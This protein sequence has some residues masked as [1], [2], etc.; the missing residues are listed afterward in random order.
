[1][2]I[3]HHSVTPN[4]SSD[5]SKFNQSPDDR[6]M[7][8]KHKTE[9]LIEMTVPLNDLIPIIKSQRNAKSMF[10]ENHD[11]RKRVKGKSKEKN[12][13]SLKDHNKYLF[14]TK[15]NELVSSD[16]NSEKKS[17]NE[18]RSKDS[19]D[20]YNFQES[21]I[22]SRGK[23]RS[24]RISVKH[25][26][27]SK[28]SP[29]LGNTTLNMHTSTSNK[30]QTGR[31]EK[32]YIQ[33]SCDKIVDQKMKDKDDTESGI[34]IPEPDY[35]P[36]L[37]R[38][39]TGQEE[40]V[41]FDYDLSLFQHPE[42]KKNSPQNITNDKN[43]KARSPT[44]WKN[45][46][47]YRGSLEK[48]QIE[49]YHDAN[50]VRDEK[51]Q[52]EDGTGSGYSK[53][54][55]TKVANTHKS[56]PHDT[57]EPYMADK[58][59]SKHQIP[60]NYNPNPLRT[61]EEAIMSLEKALTGRS[62]VKDMVEKLKKETER[63]KIKQELRRSAFLVSQCQENDQGSTGLL[64]NN[65]HQKMYR[66]GSSDALSI[67][68]VDENDNTKDTLGKEDLIIEDLEIYGDPDEDADDKEQDAIDIYK[69]LLSVAL[70]QEKLEDMRQS[71]AKLNGLDLRE[72]PMRNKKQG[73][74]SL[75]GHSSNTASELS[76]K[77]SSPTKYSTKGR[78][79]L[80][81]EHSGSGS[82]R[83]DGYDR[84][85]SRPN[86]SNHRR[87]DESLSPERSH[88]LSTAPNDNYPLSYSQDDLLESRKDHLQ[89]QSIM[90]SQPNIN[91]FTNPAVSSYPDGTTEFSHGKKMI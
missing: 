86:S 42:V 32:D 59:Q 13:K 8:Y 89:P 83:L 18:L 3:F 37:I 56:V 49:E 64:T 50:V 75:K 70:E 48:V 2:F 72:N 79:G 4:E 43:T 81:N 29:H 51:K 80:T 31:N 58:K 40:Y 73:G 57:A 68:A 78:R 85:Q 14:S 90:R 82:S 39:D 60:V 45:A 33:R 9:K 88:H 19:P 54:S 24:N 22:I 61:E 44:L 26:D 67:D 28:S 84:S 76:L 91:M 1:M 21:P 23:I 55:M 34:D 20:K 30:K 12:S 87:R 63:D 7:R 74:A 71:R 62:K 17:L 6:N 53:A 16:K 11:K 52:I 66:S 35:S 38:R 5:A 27:L 69:D 47:R 77:G 65:S 46:T 15:S 36:I 10:D 25:K 41:D